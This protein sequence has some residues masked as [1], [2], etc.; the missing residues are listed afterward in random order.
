M[1]QACQPRGVH[2]ARLV[3]TVIVLC[4][5]IAFPALGGI[6]IDFQAY[7][8][9][10]SGDHSTFLVSGDFNGDGHLD[11]AVSNDTPSTL[12]ILIGNGRGEFA[13][14]RIFPGG[15]RPA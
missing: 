4:C 2:P 5:G 9:T 11:V 3:P 6:P 1:T 13:P 10:P 7:R 14:A 15:N 8:P 12:S